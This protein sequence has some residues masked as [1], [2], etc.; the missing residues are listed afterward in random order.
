LLSPIQRVYGHVSSNLLSLQLLLIILLLLL[1]YN[2]HYYLVQWQA[3][4]M[5]QFVVKT[6]TASVGSC[7]KCPAK[8]CSPS[9]NHNLIAS[10]SN[11]GVDMLPVLIATTAHNVHH[12]ACLRAL[13]TT[14]TVGVIVVVVVVVVVV[15]G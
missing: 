3:E 12:R 10:A 4:S 1:N 7:L 6:R 11:C 2:H 13:G 15:I 5:C 14:T 9:H 8:H